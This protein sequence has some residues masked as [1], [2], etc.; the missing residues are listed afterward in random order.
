MKREYEALSRL[1]GRNFAVLDDGNS[2]YRT[3]K[4]AVRDQDGKE[5]LPAFPGRARLYERNLKQGGGT[6][7][8]LPSDVGAY[9]YMATDGAGNWN[10]EDRLAWKEDKR[11]EIMNETV[12][13]FAFVEGP[14]IYANMSEILS[15]FGM[16][17]TAKKYVVVF[18]GVEYKG[19]EAHDTGYEETWI[20]ATINAEEGTHEL[21]NEMPF[22][23]MAFTMNDE[24][25]GIGIST[26]LE[27]EE[28]SIQIFESEESIHT[29]PL[30]YLPSG[31]GG[32]KQTVFYARAQGTFNDE[33]L[34]T[35]AE[36]TVKAT[37]EDLEAAFE[38][39][40]VIVE[41][42]D[43]DEGDGW[44]IRHFPLSYSINK[45]YGS[46]VNIYPQNYGNDLTYYTREHVAGPM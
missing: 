42:Y 11:T 30:E 31:V 12:G 23:I 36:H 41:V 13:S 14:N 32:A 40:N 8:G 24:G 28:H 33:Y 17:D 1:V 26:I 39:G 16:F 10:A 15:P 4:G 38:S 27:G 7:T 21:S 3:P 2:V 19:L 18:D 46:W 44:S 20:G 29:I 6:G 43:V 34:Y 37:T 9:K 35:D 25:C 45:E 5:L 22:N